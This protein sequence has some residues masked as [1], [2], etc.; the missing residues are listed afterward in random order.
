VDDDEQAL[1]KYLADREQ[2]GAELVVVVR[3]FA[4]RPAGRQAPWAGI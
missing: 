3:S 1:E 4:P 2:M